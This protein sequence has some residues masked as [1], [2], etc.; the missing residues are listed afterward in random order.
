VHEKARERLRGS[1]GLDLAR[2]RMSH[3]SLPL[4]RF[5]LGVGFAI[6]TGHARRHLWQA[7]QVRAHAAFP[8]ELRR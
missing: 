3:P 7:Q 5:S 1:D 4:L 6:V 8:L 2:C